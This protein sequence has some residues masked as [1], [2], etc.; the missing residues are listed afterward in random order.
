M[1]S[2]I[3]DY[4]SGNLH[5]V[6]KSFRRV[7]DELG[8][9]GIILSSCPDRIAAADRV[10]LPG[11]G[12]FA[13]CRD[14][15]SRNGLADAVEHSAI[16]RG[17]PFLGICV[18]MQLLA[19]VGLEHGSTPGFGWIPGR[20]EPIQPKDAALKIP[21]MG[22]NELDA[23]PGHPLFGGLPQPTDVYFV[24]SYQFVPEDPATVAA[25]TDYGGELVAAVARDNL[26]G[27]QF[28]PEK[29]QSAGLRI[30]GNFLSWSP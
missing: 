27:V 2:V 28:H 24:H 15:L 25:R 16:R 19:T 26:C 6:E 13:A 4:G 3:V 22:W 14:A 9:D 17:V 8:T 7:S 11:V 5:S 12:A 29:S 30:I 10:I 23:V 1:A 18:G 20:V 21:H